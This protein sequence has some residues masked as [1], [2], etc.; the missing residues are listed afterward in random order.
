MIVLEDSNSIILRADISV[1]VGADRVN[2]QVVPEGISVRTANSVLDEIIV[3]LCDPEGC[4]RLIGVEARP[5]AFDHHNQV[6]VKIILLLN[7]ILNEDVVT[8]HR[9][10]DV[11]HDAHVVGAVKCVRTVE[12]LVGRATLHVRSM[13]SSNLMEVHCI[14]A[15]LETLANV[16]HLDVGESADEAVISF[17]VK[18]HVCSVL[19]SQTGLWVAAEHYISG[20]QSDLRS[21]V[22]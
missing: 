1:G 20:Q 12:A 10:N 21:H 6:V 4:W 3:R 13:D 17:R 19:V 14:A 8:L 2:L 11:V 9:V 18:E 22:D 16:G 5:A 15:Y 7:C